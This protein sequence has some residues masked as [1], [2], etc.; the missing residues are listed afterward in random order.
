MHQNR[1]K[2]K[3]WLKVLLWF[4]L[5]LFLALAAVGGLFGLKLHK[6]NASPPPTEGIT[7]FLAGLRSPAAETDWGQLLSQAAEDARAFQFGETQE[8]GL[9]ACSVPL[10]LSFLDPEKLPQGLEEEMME[11]LTQ[12]AARAVRLDELYDDS[13]HFKEELTAGAFEQLLRTRLEAPEAFLSSRH[14]TLRFSFEEDSW[15]LLNGSEVEALLL[16]DLAFDWDQIAEELYAGATENLPFLPL[17]YHIAED[18]LAGPVPDPSC[19]GE[20][21]DPAVIEELLQSP[22]AQL[23]LDGQKTAWNRDLPFLTGRPIRYYLDE[24]LLVLV[25]QEDTERA[26]GT[27]SEVVVA[28]GSQLRRRIAGDQ[29]GSL[30]F[31]TTSAFAAKTNA[32]LALG[33]DMYCHGRACGIS[34]YDRTIYR[35][36]PNTCDTCYITSGGDMLFSYR[37]QFE[38]QEQAQSFIDENDVLYSL[39]FGPVLIDGGADVTPYTYPWGEIQDLY[40]RSALGM[41]GD[42]HY[43][44]LNINCELPDHYYLVTLRVATD[45][46]LAKGCVKA[47][48]LDGGQT[49]TTVFNGKLI[50]PVQF[51]WEK[52]ISDV[53]YFAS[54]VP[55]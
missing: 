54:A 37:G 3:L 48:T 12:T 40:A 50:N 46:M 11:T 10:S 33:G 44:S 4:L 53:L 35:F 32:V 39:C 8:E 6:R 42:R 25:W 13:L 22:L 9:W 16:S 2:K 15:Q 41:L 38:T 52:I 24:S 28:D 49:A 21:E 26:V 29:F 27:F 7:D 45:A 47:Y 36:E 55:N 14:L 30:E 19:F 1:K 31:E 20:T 17:H 51:G 18:A 43:L 34:V 23:L 5:L